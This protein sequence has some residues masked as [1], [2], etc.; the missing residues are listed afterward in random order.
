MPIIPAPSCVSHELPHAQFTSL[1]TPRL[2]SRETSLWRVRLLPGSEPTLHSV[3]R[4]EIFVVLRGKA[5]VQIAH[6]LHEVGEGAAIVV[7]P[8]VSFGLSSADD[9]PVDLLCCLPVG[10]QARLGDGPLFTPPWAE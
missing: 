9:Q 3:T 4:E 8:D 6:A 5:R 10:G 7:P 2:G 1:A